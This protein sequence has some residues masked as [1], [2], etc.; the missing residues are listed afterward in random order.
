MI[1]QPI[2][3]V[4]GH[5]DHGKTTLLDNIR[6]STVAAKEAGL[7]TQ[8]I[9]ATE[10][11]L[12]SIKSMCSSLLGAEKIKIP[13]LLFLDTPGHEAFTTLRKRGSSIADMAILIV[14]VNEGL[15][16]QTEESIT[17]LKEYKT[18][19]IVAMNKIDKLGWKSYGGFVTSLQKQPPKVIE[20]LDNAIYTFMGKLSERG[21]DA[22]R[23]DRVRDYR[24]TIAIVPISGMLGF[25]I[26]ELIAMLVGLS[27]QFLSA[28]LDIKE[29]AGKGS[30]LEVK[31][32]K[33]LGVAV[34][35]ILYDGSMREG[36]YLIIGGKQPLVTTIR[37]LLKPPPLGEM[38][39]EKKF[40]RVKEV[41][42]AS[43]IKISATGLEEAIAGMPFSTT[44][45]KQEIETMKEELKEQVSETEIEETV[46]GATI[47]A[48]T[49]GSLEA[50][51]KILRAEDVPIKR[52]R[53]GSVTRKDVM[54]LKSMPED[55]RILFAFNVPVLKDAEDEAKGDVKIFKSNI[56]YE[57]LQE[58]EKWKADWERE[59]EK[60]MLENVIRPGRI[61]FLN[62]YVFRQRKP[63]IIGIEIEKGLIRTGYYVMVDGKTIGRIVDIQ[64]EGKSVGEAKQGEQVAVSI[65]GPTVGRQLSEGNVLYNR[66]GDE[67]LKKLRG[68][69]KVLSH[70]ELEVL[71]ELEKARY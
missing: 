61:R 18:P 19:F 5:V 9:G 63:A 24:K 43:G 6:K 26:P 50:I 71:E 30:I 35:A 51:V 37:S 66:L 68:M 70:G 45:N 44:R 62:G 40:E 49:L 54:E 4:M 67:D 16:P 56:I 59:R 55:K 11:P 15:M 69:K 8:H 29:G 31:E 53:M 10:V 3:V 57:L 20:S 39:V 17:L 38:R 33:G 2:V 34:D 13:G 23:F 28:E 22:D 65:D 41:H 25:G 32:V 36:D 21:F 42:A 47:K 1:R 12:D 48:D 27:Q 60:A 52:A 14:D 7:I 46:D 64:K 58:Y